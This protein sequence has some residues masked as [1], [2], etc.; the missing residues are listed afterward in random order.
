[1]PQLGFRQLLFTIPLIL[2]APQTFAFTIKATDGVGRYVFTQTQGWLEADHA[3]SGFHM[4]DDYVKPNIWLRVFRYDTAK[5]D[6][7]G[8]PNNETAGNNDI[9]DWGT[10]LAG[11]NPPMRG[12]DYY[13]LLKK[14]D[15]ATNPADIDQT[16]GQCKASGRCYG[17]WV[18]DDLIWDDKVKSYTGKNGEKFLTLNPELNGQKRTRYRIDIFVEDNTPFWFKDKDGAYDFNQIPDLVTNADG[19]YDRTAVENRIGDNEMYYPYKNVM[20]RIATES[21]LT[22]NPVPAEDAGDAAWENYLKDD[23]WAEYYVVKT[24]EELRVEDMDLEFRRKNGRLVLNFAV[25]HAFQQQDDY[26]M[27]VIA[28]DMSLNTRVLQVY[29]S[30]DRLKGLQINDKATGVQK[31][32]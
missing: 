25:Y 27:Q 26:V 30:M 5:S 11:F 24:E 14:V 9:V 16:T 3:G 4:N 12:G 6:V 28:Q 23:T 32:D 29:L 20:F 13:K 19:S 15:F 10:S 18:N 22:S 1:M 2:L 17:D 31:Y 8:L 21:K 7:A